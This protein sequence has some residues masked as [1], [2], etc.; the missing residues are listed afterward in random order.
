M[1]TLSD[2]STVELRL[3]KGILGGLML[4]VA[5]GVEM[6]IRVS[7]TSER[8][9]KCATKEDVALLVKAMLSDELR[10]VLV[11]QGVLKARVDQLRSELDQARAKG[12]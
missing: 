1:A 12:G 10:S 7:D 4:L 11:E 6:R 2:T 5:G 9:A 3:L 8:V